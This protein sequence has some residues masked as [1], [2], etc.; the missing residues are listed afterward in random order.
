MSAI[1][2]CGCTENSCDRAAGHSG[3]CNSA[4]ERIPSEPPFD[5]IATDDKIVACVDRALKGLST[6]DLET[7][8]RELPTS[9]EEK[10][11]PLGYL[12]QLTDRDTLARW[13]AAWRMRAA[14]W[15]RIQPS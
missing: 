15:A 2:L 1:N 8:A 3:R 12:D 10:A 11:A 4:L 7:I 5:W 9:P 13:R 14:I 6:V